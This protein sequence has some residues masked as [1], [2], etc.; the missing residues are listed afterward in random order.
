MTS[1]GFEGIAK[2]AK[3]MAD[4]S[5]IHFP[6][7]AKQWQPDPAQFQLPNFEI[8]KNPVLENMEENWAS[9]F[10][11]R[12]KNWIA[13]FDAELDE[14]HEVGVRLVSFGQTVVF[15]LKHLG[16]S[17][18][19]LIAFSGTTDSGDPVHL[20][21]HV[22]QISILLMKLPRKDPESPKQP[23][24]FSHYHGDRNPPPTCDDAK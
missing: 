20:I 2:I 3:Q 23:F 18:P 1:D 19:S 11:E 5:R 22:S 16:F 21:Q 13:E 24:G 17:N 9:A 14:G 6:E 15:H 4:A 7:P 10:H 8:P 12:L